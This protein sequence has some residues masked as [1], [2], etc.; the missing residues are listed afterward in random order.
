[1]YLLRS[2]S[3]LAACLLVGVL[4]TDA[5]VQ[6]QQCVTTPPPPDAVVLFNGKDCAGWTR[7]NGQPA[8]WTVEGG[9]M[10][11]RDHDV[12]T[13]PV[14]GDHQLHIE[15][16]VPPKPAPDTQG[17]GNSGV[18]LHGVYEIQVI[19]S[20]GIKPHKSESCGAVYGQA[21]PLVDAA[22]AAGQWQSFDVFFQAPR[23]DWRG[24]VRGNARISM[25]HN[26]VIIHRDLEIE[27]TPGGL[28]GERFGERG[29][30]LLQHHGYPV[31]FRN[32][33]VRRLPQA[34]DGPGETAI[35]LPGGSRMQMVRIPAGSFTMGTPPTEAD[36]E[37]DEQQYRVTITRDFWMGQFEVTNAQFRK[38]RPGH[39]S[40]KN[41]NDPA[42]IDSF[43]VTFV[44]WDD[45]AAFCKWAS[46][47]TGWSVR[48][49][50]EAEWE[51]ASRA[52][53]S[54]RYSFGDDVGQLKHYARYLENSS[55]GRKHTALPV[56]QLRP[57]PWGLYDIHGNVAEWCQDWYGDYPRVPAVDPQGRPAGTKRVSREG[58]HG[59]NHYNCRAGDRDRLEPD[60][61][62]DA[63]GFRV[64]CSSPED[65]MLAPLPGGQEMVF[66]RIKAGSFVMGS[67]E[68][69]LREDDETQ[70]P[71]TLTRDFWMGKFEVTNKQFR[72][73]RPDHVSGKDKSDPRNGDDYPASGVSWDDAAA[74]CAWMSEK[75]GRPVRLPTEA[76][77][78]YACRAG[79]TSVYSFG[80]DIHELGKYAWYRAN[81][82]GK[83]QPVG[84]LR[85]NPWG[86]YDMHGNVAEWC[87]DWYGPYPRDPVFDPTG[88]AT[89]DRRVAREGSAASEHYNAR[90]AD[91][92]R[93]EPTYKGDGMGFRVV[94]PDQ[95]SATR[96]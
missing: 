44:T 78:E 64:V 37:P 21:A 19:D 12:L 8:E 33:W 50:T 67:P 68:T 87:S 11:A 69:G 73:F 61:K 29:P 58:S 77:R 63:L 35:L 34:V 62:C 55:E 72:L 2:Q 47:R 56:G 96:K 41:A 9:V 49:P 24:K 92:D 13:R 88:P 48:L 95:W 54:T 86:L 60:F 36:R 22:L 15:F 39:V 23:F 46:D 91:R 82:N 76:E 53:T 31:R 70:H 4:L 75:T 1:M 16:Q 45:A 79:T 84:L 42:N 7:C 18:Y 85:P 40:G 93:V 5:S 65:H 10:V 94:F 3:V 32:I 30:L 89:G 80:D 26:G 90:S 17:S 38:F 43:P 6:G 66:L 83:A 25:L 74:F 51:Y 81:V 59:S 57:N 27:P 28:P 14:F 52:G 71:V 20:A